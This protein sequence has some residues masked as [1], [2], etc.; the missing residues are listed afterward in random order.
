MHVRALHRIREHGRHDLHRGVLSGRSSLPGDLERLQ[1]AGVLQATELMRLG[2]T[3][4][5]FVLLSPSLAF[6]EGGLWVEGTVGLRRAIGKHSYTDER[7]PG[8]G[9]SGPIT[10]ETD[11][12]G[13]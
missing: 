13:T 5:C 4:L 8:F 11:L 12:N 3:L 7:I 2:G 10:L 1:R 6:A 9:V